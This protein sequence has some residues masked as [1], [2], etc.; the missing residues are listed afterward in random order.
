MTKPH[1]TAQQTAK[2]GLL[3]LLSNPVSPTPRTVAAVSLIHGGI[4]TIRVNRDDISHELLKR[5]DD[6]THDHYLSYLAR[7][8][9]TDGDYEIRD[10]RGRLQRIANTNSRRSICIAIRAMLPELKPYVRIENSVP[11]VYDLSLIPAEIPHDNRHVPMLLMRYAG[12]RVGEAVAITSDDC[13]GN[14]LRVTKSRTNKGVVKRT[15]GN[16]GN[17]VIPEWLAQ[18]LHNYEGTEVLPNSYFKWM[19][20][21]YGINPHALR[22]EYATRLIKSRINPE[23]VRRQLRHA[24][25]TTTLGI[26]A[27]VEA[28][29]IEAEIERVVQC[30]Q[31]APEATLTA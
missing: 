27:Q 3:V 16:A 8:G 14:V 17:V 4:V 23:I 9:L 1:D 26:Y 22:H 11:R 18:L 30:P 19:K 6:A 10:I 5:V 21:N 29:D 20:R 13:V 25:L 7:L 15:K 28:S 12:L 2:Q 24:N 31:N